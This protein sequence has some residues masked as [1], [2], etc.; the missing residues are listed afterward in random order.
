MVRYVFED[1]PA[2]KYELLAEIFLQDVMW[3]RL[4]NIFHLLESGWRPF[5]SDLTIIDELFNHLMESI[6][7]AGKNSLSKIGVDEFLA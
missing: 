3:A 2:R 5:E 1:F 4:P 7:I 6:D